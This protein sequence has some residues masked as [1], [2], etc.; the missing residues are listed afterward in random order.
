M[1]Q[2]PG[3]FRQEAL[4]FHTGQ[5][6]PG[7]VLHGDS[8]WTRW[9]YW[10]MLAL[11]LAGVAFTATAHTSVTTAGSA[12]VDVHDRTFVALVPDASSPD[13]K[14]G[15]L[16]QLNVQGMTGRPLAGRTLTTAVADQSAIRQAGF[17]SSSQP[18]VLV[19]GVLAPDAD[20]AS[21]PP[22]PRHEGRAVV[23]LSSQRILDMFLRQLRGA[24]GNGGGG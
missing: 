1:T 22:S 19:T 14:P 9:A 16:V 11:L 10:I 15:Q 3:L 12:L 6:R 8:P 21:L 13:L 20:V 4:E 7:G 17:A 5:P 2:Q 24:L 18:A 23:V